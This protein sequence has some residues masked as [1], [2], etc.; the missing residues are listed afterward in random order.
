MKNILFIATIYRCG[1]KVYPIIDTLKS[2]YNVDILTMYQMSQSFGWTGDFDFRQK[3]YEYH[4]NCVNGLNPKEILNGKK[5]NFINKGLSKYDAIIIDDNILKANRGLDSL[6][7]RFRSGLII[8]CPHGNVE[9][10]NFKIRLD[11]F[12]DYSF[13]LGK[14]E[15]YLLSKHNNAKQLIPGGI[16]SNDVLKNCKLKNEYILVVVGYVAHKSQKVN[17][18]GYSYFDEKTFLNSGILDVQQ[19]TGKKI[20]I[21]EKSRGKKTEQPSLKFLE[22]Y[23]GV[24]VIMDHK[25]DNDLISNAA[26]LI[27]A[28]STLCFKAIQV[29]VPTVLLRNY[30]VTGNFYDWP[31]FVECKKN[32]VMSALQNQ[33]MGYRNKEWISQTLEGGYEFNSSS[34]YINNINNII[35]A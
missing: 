27:S 8:G 16:P 15:Q 30:G 19:K 1:E 32:L 23:D 25:N 34:I 17:R 33:E 29:G 14:K 2:I 20:I 35:G 28:P 6:R 13:V 26:C 24:S 5:D 10:E 4:K 12:F 21:K 22:K 11:N 7:K 3:F 18:S 31:F 9:F